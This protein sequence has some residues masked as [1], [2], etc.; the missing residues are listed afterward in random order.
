MEQN[1]NHEIINRN[2]EEKHSIRNSNKQKIKYSSVKVVILDIEGTTTPISF[3]TETL[4]PYVRKHLR[5]YL[6]FN[7]RTEETQADILQLKELSDTEVKSNVSDTKPIL[8]WP[9]VL[10]ETGDPLSERE[11]EVLESVVSNVLCQM[12]MDRKSTAL[13]QLQ[14]H[15]WKHAYESGQIK[16][17]VYKDVIEALKIWKENDIFVYIYSSGSVEAQKLLFKYSCYGNLLD[18]LSGHFDTTSGMKTEGKSY[19]TIF[20]RIVSEHSISEKFK[21]REYLSKENVLFVT[22][23][24]LEARAASNCGFQVVL[25]DRPGN[26][27]LP[28]NHG[29]PLIRSFTELFEEKEK[30]DFSDVTIV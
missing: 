15:I 1:Q 12:D 21:Q 30:N 23:N 20:E 17:Y 26:K 8:E 6:Q 4:F 14:G 25:A 5:E 22:D 27:S 3:V 28:E 11:K 18:F 16:G 13:K 19:E 10:S 7:W 29:F 9:I 2:E 24:I